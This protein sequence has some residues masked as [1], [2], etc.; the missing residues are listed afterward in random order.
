MEWHLAHTVAASFFA[1]FGFLMDAQSFLGGLRVLRTGRGPKGLFFWPLLSYVVAALFWD[2][3][4]VF[5]AEAISVGLALHLISTVG[6]RS[7][8]KKRT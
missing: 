8:R 2:I 5:R 7:I 6:L 1:L 3:S 4:W